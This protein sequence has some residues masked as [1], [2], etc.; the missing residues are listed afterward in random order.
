MD[1][2]GYALASR[3]FDRYTRSGQQGEEMS[4][5]TAWVS[6]ERKHLTAK[7]VE[8]PPLL[9]FWWG[10]YGYK[11]G[12]TLG[13]LMAVNNLSARLARGGI[14][15]AVVSHTDLRLPDHLSVDDIYSIQPAQKLVFVCGP[16]TDNRELRDLLSIHARAKKVAVGVSVL[17]NQSTMNG[18]F[19]RIVARDGADRSYFD[20]AIAEFVA[21]AQRGTTFSTVGVCLRGPQGE[22]GDARKGMAQLAETVFQDVVRQNG[23]QPISIDTVLSAKNTPATINAQLAASDIV[24]TTRMHGALLALAAG[25]PVIAIDQ[26][27]GGAKVAAVV[28]K[29]GWP[30]VFR[31]ENV[32]P[33]T[34]HEA[35][36]NL[37]RGDWQAQVLAAQG[38]IRGMTDEALA[39]SV[40]AIED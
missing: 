30:F 13:D 35:V 21:P 15:H 20:L 4:L 3:I 25:K 27:P 9:L 33:E 26:V 2:V 39:A 34:I 38:Q 1:R 5:R 8:A 28:G 29:T 14:E 37:R 24:L 10:S 12:P 19:D 40:A 6:F 22:Y 36:D 32:G 23:F 7:T 17:T 11:G 31:A 18:R 16:V